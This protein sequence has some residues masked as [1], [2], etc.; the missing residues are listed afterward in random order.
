MF[1]LNQQFITW[2]VVADC[3][4]NITTYIRTNKKKK[5]EIK[6]KKKRKRNYIEAE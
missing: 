3:S 2:S 1:F 6:M 4:Y 5:K